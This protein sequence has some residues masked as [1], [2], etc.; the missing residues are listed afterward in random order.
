MLQGAKVQDSGDKAKYVRVFEYDVSAL[1]D[2]VTFSASTGNPDDKAKLM[3]EYVVELPTSKNGKVRSVSEFIYLGPEL[4]ELLVCD[5]NGFGDDET[6]AKYK[7]VD[8]IDLSRATNVAGTEYDGAAGAVA[9]DG[10]LA[11]GI[12]TAGYSLIDYLADLM[13]FG[14]HASDPP[15]D[16]TLIAAKIESL[17]LLPTLPGDGYDPD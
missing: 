17:V 10:T 11:K 16:P 7:H 5:G 3:G 14:M 8:V 9:S 12:T 15:V 6:D 13:R 2:V 1:A 4:L